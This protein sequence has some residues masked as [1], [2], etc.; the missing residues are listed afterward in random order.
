MRVREIGRQSIELVHPTAAQAKRPRFATGFPAF[1]SVADSVY[2]LILLLLLMPQLQ[3]L[4]TSEVNSF[5]LPMRLKK[6]VFSRIYQPFN[7]TLGLL[8]HSK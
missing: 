3:L 2:L 1:S 4:V 5:S 8:R 6:S 7:N